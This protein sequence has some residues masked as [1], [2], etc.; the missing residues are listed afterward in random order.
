MPIVSKGDNLLEMSKTVF[1]EKITKT[2]I[3]NHVIV[4]IWPENGEGKTNLSFF[5]FFV[6][7]FSR[8]NSVNTAC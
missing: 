7:E 4:W 6:F 2:K 3:Q 5:C 8:W 1:W